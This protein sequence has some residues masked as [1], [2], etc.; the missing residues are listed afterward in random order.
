MSLG[1]GGELV[2]AHVLIQVLINF[3]DHLLDLLLLAR[4]LIHKK[5]SNKEKK[6]NS[7]SV[8]ETQHYIL[9]HFV[10]VFF[11]LYD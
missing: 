11:Q 8:K 3:P 10:L 5:G 7:D 9:Y 4:G 6:L 1:H 2:P